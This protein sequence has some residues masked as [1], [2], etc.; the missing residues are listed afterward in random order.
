MNVENIIKLENQVTDKEW[1]LYLATAYAEGFCEGENATLTEQ[2]E[3]WACLIKTGDCWCLQGWFGRCASS[4]IERGIITKEGVI[5][6][7]NI[8]E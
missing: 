6:W 7:E 4:L 1:T 8:E 5:N 3:A 2:L